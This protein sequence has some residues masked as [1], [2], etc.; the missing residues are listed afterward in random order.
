MGIA[1]ME[2]KKKVKIMENCYTFN[3]LRITNSYCHKHTWEA[4][5]TQKLKPYVINVR[6]YRGSEINTDRY[7]LVS[8]VILP[9]RYIKKRN[10][11]LNVKMFLDIKHTCLK[12]SVSGNGIKI[13]LINSRSRIKK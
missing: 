13:D 3:S 9:Q 1:Y 2:S 7:L 12:K 4:I 5:I 6:V 11:Y 8:N 10:L